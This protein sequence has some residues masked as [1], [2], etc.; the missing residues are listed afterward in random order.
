M[1]KVPSRL[2]PPSRLVRGYAIAADIEGVVAP[3]LML[4]PALKG[5]PAT[6]AFPLPTAVARLWLLPTTLAVLP[7]PVAC[8]SVAP[9]VAGIYASHTRVLALVPTYVTKE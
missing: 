7:S 4:L 3:L 9:A 6:T 1:E 8:A 5:D 2:R